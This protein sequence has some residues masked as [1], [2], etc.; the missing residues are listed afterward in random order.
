MAIGK[1][2]GY[3]KL[4]PTCG[5]RIYNGAD[6]LHEC[7]FDDDEDYVHGDLY[8]SIDVEGKK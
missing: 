8:E 6:K 2:P 3:F 1:E 7:C 5:N 4:C